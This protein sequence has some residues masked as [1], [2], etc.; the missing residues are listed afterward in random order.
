MTVS[1]G[2]CGTS[3]FSCS[4]FMPFSLDFVIFVYFTNFKFFKP[5]SDIAAFRSPV[6]GGAHSL[7]GESPTCARATI[8]ALGILRL[9]KSLSLWRGGKISLTQPSRHF[10][11]V[12][13]LSF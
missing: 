4:F 1:R 10:V 2:L 8:S 13:S 11:R 12:R 5:W 7:C 3:H 9:S 6:F